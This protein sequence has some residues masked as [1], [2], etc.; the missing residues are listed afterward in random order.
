MKFGLRTL[1]R[2]VN[3]LWR[4]CI[5]PVGYVDHRVYMRLYARYLRHRGVI[6]DGFPLYVSPSAELDLGY[7]GSLSLGDRCVIS[8]GV[9]LLVHDFS[10]D[11]FIESSRN[12]SSDRSR[13]EYVLV[14]PVRIGKGSFLGAGSIILPGV[15]IGDGA[16]VGAGAVVRG[17]VA[18]NAIV[19]GNPASQISTVDD[20]GPRAASRAVQR[21]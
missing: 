5:L 14:S 1:G 7:P 8:S 21:N 20:W 19:I 13:K 2:V 4:L 10:I 18:P 3:L 6:L 9:R 12:E 11:R 17:H 15:T 16:I